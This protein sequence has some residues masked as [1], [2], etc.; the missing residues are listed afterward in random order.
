[1]TIAKKV[2]QSFHITNLGEYHD[3]YLT[4]DVLQLAD[5]FEN[6][7]DMSILKVYGLD[8]THYGSTPSLAWNAI[9]K[10]TKV[11][12]EL[13]SE[14]NH[15]MYYWIESDIRGGIFMVSKKFARANHPK[16]KKY[17]PDL[18]MNDPTHTHR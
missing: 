5:V 13:S 6:F 16:M 11:K 4:C 1:M 9:L 7:R 8:P 3:L 10:I 2:W 18:V 12:L 17:N 15:D 14:K